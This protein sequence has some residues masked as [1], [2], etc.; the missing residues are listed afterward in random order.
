MEAKYY[1]PDTTEFHLGF[2]FEWRYRPDPSISN[3]RNKSNELVLAIDLV[4]F[5]T[6]FQKKK[7]KEEKI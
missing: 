7:Y 4:F 6:D 3:L 1:A 2:E 5:P